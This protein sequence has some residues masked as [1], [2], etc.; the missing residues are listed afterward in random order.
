MRIFYLLA[1]ID[2]RLVEA[3]SLGRPSEGRSE[4]QK[5]YGV[6]IKREE[7]LPFFYAAPRMLS[8]S[9]CRAAWSSIAENDIAEPPSVALASAILIN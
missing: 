4:A 8:Q 7:W 5:I 6:L 3:G 2:S 1:S 9:L